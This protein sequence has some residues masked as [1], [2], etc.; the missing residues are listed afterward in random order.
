MYTNTQT[1]TTIKERGHNFLNLNEIGGGN[2]YME[3]DGERKKKWANNIF[4][5]LKLTGKLTEKKYVVIQ[6]VW[7][8]NIS[9]IPIKLGTKIKLEE[10]KMTDHL[11]STQTWGIRNNLSWHDLWLNFIE[12]NIFM[13]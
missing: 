12:K 9:S 1:A 10:K 7:K 3:E 13:V 5:I 4:I 6:G 2:V 11:G 8:W